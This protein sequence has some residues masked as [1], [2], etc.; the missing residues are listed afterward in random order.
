MK[1]NSLTRQRFIVVLTVTLAICFA[2]WFEGARS[3]LAELVLI[4]IPVAAALPG[5]GIWFIWRALARRL[6]IEA[7]SRRTPQI[8]PDIPIRNGL[9]WKRHDLAPVIK[10]LPDFGHYWSIIL[11]AT[12][13]VFMILW[14]PRT[15]DGLML[16]LTV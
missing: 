15:P 8:F 1:P 9:P 11:N 5:A 16:P 12:M 14:T 6:H 10:D 2:I 4:L 7:D 3:L 13:F